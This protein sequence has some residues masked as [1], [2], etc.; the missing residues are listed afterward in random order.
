MLSHV[1][2]LSVGFRFV[3]IAPACTLDLRL[4]CV[5]VP[6]IMHVDS[7]CIMHARARL[8]GWMHERALQAADWISAAIRSMDIGR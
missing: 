7:A 1:G 4:W 5:Y 8:A 3:L 2:M 6:Y